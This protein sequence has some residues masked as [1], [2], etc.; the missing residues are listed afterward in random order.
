M[1]SLHFFLSVTL[2]LS[3][4][5]GWC[6]EPSDNSSKNIGIITRFFQRF[7]GESQSA[8]CQ[9]CRSGQPTG[10]GHLV[11]ENS[12]PGKWNAPQGTSS[13]T[14]LP[15]GQPMVASSVLSEEVL[16]AMKKEE[17][18]QLELANE[19]ALQVEHERNKWFNT[20]VRYVDERSQEMGEQ[21]KKDTKEIAKG[22]IDLNYTRMQELAREKAQLKK[23]TLPQLLAHDILKTK[24]TH[25]QSMEKLHYIGEGLKNFLSD[26]E[27]MIIT[28]TTLTGVAFGFYA[29][30]NITRVA[31]NIVESRLMKP[32]LVTETSRKSANQFLKSPLSSMRHLFEKK[33]PVTVMYNPKLQ[34]RVDRYVKAI[35]KGREDKM[36]YRN[37]L[38]YGMPG[39]G[40]TLLAKKI[41]QELDMDY[42]II[43]GA[44]VHQF[45]EQDSVTELNKLFNWA[46]SSPKGVVLFFDE[47]DALAA[48]REGNVSEQ[49]RKIQNTF[50]ARTGTET[51][52]FMILGATNVPRL[53]D[54]AF[55]SRMDEKMEFELPDEQTRMYLL[56]HYFKRYIQDSL[57]SSSLKLDIDPDD[58]NS[59]LRE[60]SCNLT[61]FSG[62]EI[63]QLVRSIRADAYSQPDNAIT[64]KVIDQVVG[65][66][67][68]EHKSINDL[69]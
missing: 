62:R 54:Q 1:I 19:R 49:T 9:T 52:R 50:Y 32:R 28:A 14:V 40:K 69:D 24:L 51:N 66:K 18:R 48:R 26:H 38:F 47:V 30:K 35:K 8:T 15:V 55:I 33:D 10:N 65:Q 42:A 36:P 27:R 5:N 2:F 68:E 12:V 7:F 3:F 61:G 21:Q 63:S 23:E 59:C 67:I 46:E 34:K 56:E 13:G 44:N 25:K 57:E 45:N 17:T 39:T 22:M 64:Q 20:L 4:S 60:T 11:N 53:L 37:A 58:L 43:P 6:S 41:A 31:A 29:S 16:I